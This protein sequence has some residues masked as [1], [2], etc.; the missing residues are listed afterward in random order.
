MKKKRTG[1]PSRYRP[2]FAE[3]A[4]LLCLL[5]H[6]D[7]DL[8]SVFEVGESTL[9]RWKQEHEDF[10]EALAR[11]RA[12]ADA[13]VAESLYHRALGY[14][15]TVHKTVGLG[16]NQG[17]EL[18]EVEETVPPDT[19]A[20]SLWLR[21]RQPKLWRDKVDV[22]VDAPEGNSLVIVGVN[23]PGAISPEEWER[24]KRAQAD[25]AAG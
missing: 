3:Q 14:K 8:A 18:V 16:G 10:R 22:E 15:R 23:V 6:T 19:Q 20:A 11:G 13:K 4:R 24:R 2:E 17:Q 25:D 5:G 1:R 7:K 9:N 12:R 21:N